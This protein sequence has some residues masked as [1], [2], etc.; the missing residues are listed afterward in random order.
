MLSETSDPLLRYRLPVRIF[1]I[2]RFNV[3]FGNQHAS[4]GGDGS[5]LEAL[6]A[7][8]LALVGGA[9]SADDC[10][11]SHKEIFTK[12]PDA[13]KKFPIK[14]W[15][16]Q[17][18]KFSCDQREGTGMGKT[19][20]KQ[21]RKWK[22]QMGKPLTP[23]PRRAMWGAPSSSTKPSGKTL[24]GKMSCPGNSLNRLS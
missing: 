13:V 15:G 19:K 17:Y 1:Q 20:G 12:Y 24:S 8:E 11:L 18:C 10:S 9:P 2:E 22:I 14:Q 23:I 7:L 5:H 4:P 21:L 6:E 16:F 3:L